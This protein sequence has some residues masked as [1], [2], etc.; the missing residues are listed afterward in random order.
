[1][2]DGGGGGGGGDTIDAD[3]GPRD[4]CGAA[5]ATKHAA[6]RLAQTAHER[7]RPFWHLP[8]CQTSSPSL[9]G[10]VGLV[11]LGGYE[12]DKSSARH[13]EPSQDRKVTP[14]ST[15]EGSGGALRV[16]LI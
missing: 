13:Q 9:V 11:R 3:S 1:M 12:R 10:W 5:V 15:W 2:F 7:P 16:P 6:P 8:E 4:Q 14:E